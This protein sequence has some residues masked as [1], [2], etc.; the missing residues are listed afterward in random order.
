MGL[1]VRFL[2]RWRIKV[3]DA[4]E[5]KERNGFVWENTGNYGELQFQ[6]VFL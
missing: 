5:W 3:R 2:P 1:Q 6:Q 4:A